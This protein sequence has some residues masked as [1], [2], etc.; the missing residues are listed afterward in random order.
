MPLPAVIPALNALF[1]LAALGMMTQDQSPKTPPLQAHPSQYD[2]GLWL[3]YEPLPIGV[4][5]YA[6]PLEPIR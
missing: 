4:P 5:R 1:A 2:I 3:P 6:A